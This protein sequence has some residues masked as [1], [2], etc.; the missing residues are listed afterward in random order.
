MPY[1][2]IKKVG[3]GT[4]D[5]AQ[6]IQEHIGTFTSLAALKSIEAPRGHSGAI[7]LYIVFGAIG[8][9]PNLPTGEV[10]AWMDTETAA[11][12]G[13]TCLRPSSAASDAVAGRWL[14]LSALT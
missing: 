7:A 14:K 3:T 13:T 9:A 12:N 4:T 8:G 10:F 11:D 5:Y 6:Y 2:P 1:G